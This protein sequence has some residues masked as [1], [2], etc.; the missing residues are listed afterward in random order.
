MEAC[1]YMK[2]CHENQTQMKHQAQKK[3]NVEEDKIIGSGMQLTT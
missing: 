2:I 3:N 1:K